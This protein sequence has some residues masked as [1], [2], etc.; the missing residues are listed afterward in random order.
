MEQKQMFETVV[1]LMAIAF[2]VGAFF[3]VTVTLLMVTL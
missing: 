3:G 2:I 1:V